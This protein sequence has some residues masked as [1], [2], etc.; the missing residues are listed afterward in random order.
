[1]TSTFKKSTNGTLRLNI[2]EGSIEFAVRQGNLEHVER[3]GSS[4]H[5]DRTEILADDRLVSMAL[6]DEAVEVARQRGLRTTGGWERIEG[7]W[8]IPVAS[9]PTPTRT[10]RIEDPLWENA[11]RKAAEQNTNV[12]AIIVEAVQK[13]VNN[14]ETPQRTYE[15]FSNV[16]MNDLTG[17]Y[18]PDT[19][20]A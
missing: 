8:R 20:R 19:V 10:V 2:D 6:M 9:G 17:D 12:S 3:I 18:T 14:P 15:R 16:S 1:M 5:S 13:F 7:G 4:S 11:K